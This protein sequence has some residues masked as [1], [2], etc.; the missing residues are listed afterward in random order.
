[1]DLG[2]YLF[3]N[4]S[5]PLNPIFRQGTEAEQCYVPQLSNGPVLTEILPNSKSHSYPSLSAFLSEYKNRFV[6]YILFT[7]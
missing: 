3:L 7:F 6:G 1:M 4:P 5:V 2:S